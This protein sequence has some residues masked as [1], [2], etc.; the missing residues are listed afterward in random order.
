[1]NGNGYFLD[2]DFDLYEDDVEEDEF[3]DV[4]D[5]DDFDDDELAELFFG[6]A[7]DDDAERRRGRRRRGRRRRLSP[8]TGGQRRYLRRRPSGRYVTQPQLQ[9]ALERVRRDVK[10]NGNAIKKVNSRVNAVSSRQDRQEGALKKEIKMR[11]QETAKLKNNIQMATLLPLL[12]KPKA[13]TA[14]TAADTVGGAPVPVGTKLTTES[15][16]SLSALL[17]I[18]LL[19]DG[20]GGSGSG[21]DSSNMLLL[22]LALS[23]GL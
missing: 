23:G 20:L 15:S 22:V 6:E 3:D 16:D 2:E 1:M 12:T 13:L 19:G 17:P 21:G 4:D 10:K 5:F 18:L 14:T 8:R 7:D 9:A 11:K